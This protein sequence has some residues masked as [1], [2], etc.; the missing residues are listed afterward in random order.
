MF[1][2]SFSDIVIADK[3]YNEDG[4]FFMYGD[5]YKFHQK[6]AVGVTLKE[7]MTIGFLKYLL[8]FPYTVIHVC[9]FPG[10]KDPEEIINNWRSAEFYGDV[11]VLGIDETLVKNKYR[12]TFLE[13]DVEGSIDEHDICLSWSEPGKTYLIV[14]A[15][16]PGYL[17]RYDES[18]KLNM[19]K[20]ANTIEDK[21]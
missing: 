9:T 13:Y 1:L 18:S 8:G 12:A 6:G 15:A 20:I 19:M 4:L 10:E 2:L 5:K 17:K 14:S 16:K 11:T 21:C 3:Y 7:N